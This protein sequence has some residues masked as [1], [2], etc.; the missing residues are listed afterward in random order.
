MIQVID[1][2][3]YAAAGIETL[4]FP[5]G[6]PHVKIPRFSEPVLLY[7]KTRTW[8]DVGFG[9]LVLDALKRQLP[10]DRVGLFLPYF[11][12]ARQ[13]RSDGFAA[14]TVEVLARLF[15]NAEV[16]VF[17]PH[18]QET[19]NQLHCAQVFMPA[20]LPIERHIDGVIAPDAG[21]VRRA[22]QFCARFL[23]HGAPFLTCSKSRDAS[24]GRLSNYQMPRLPTP[25]RYI[26]VDDICDGGGTF[27]LLAEAWKKDPLSADSSLELF[28]SHGIFSRG[29][30]AIDPAYE[31]ITTTDSWC[32]LPSNER[33]TVIPL[34]PNI[35]KNLGG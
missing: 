28:V 17:D 22:S 11:P 18:S 24:T 32:Q 3:N 15:G 20:D 10:S 31:H 26:V 21:A 29:L 2:D 9:A 6:E 4:C 25:G 35:L 27:N 34:L 1:S 16:A 14:K 19:L 7:L 8:L 23:G 5:G 13:D 30:D 33:L 12:G